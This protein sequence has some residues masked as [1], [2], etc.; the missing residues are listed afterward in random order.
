MPI[1]KSIS[2]IISGTPKIV[3]IFVS[4]NPVYLKK[5]IIKRLIVIVSA[6]TSFFVEFFSQ[7]F[8]IIRAESQS[9][10]VIPTKI[11]T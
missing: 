6:K 2:G 8:C 3:F 10:N 1:G 4:K 11:K 5:P 9:T 7:V